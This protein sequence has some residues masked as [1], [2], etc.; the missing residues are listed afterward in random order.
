MFRATRSSVDGLFGTLE[1]LDFFDSLGTW[2]EYPA[3]SADGQSLCFT[4]AGEGS[5]YDIY[6][7]HVVPVRGA[8]LLGTIGIAYSGW[9]LRRRTA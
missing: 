6:V 8:V 3:I 4:R 1:R 2:L 7:S 9:W 5:S